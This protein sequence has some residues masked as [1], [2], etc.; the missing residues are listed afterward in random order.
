MALNPFTYDDPVSPQE[1]IDRSEVLV[2]LL[3]LAEGGHN[4]RLQA[5][6]RYG[7]TS[8]LLKLCQEAETAGFRTIYVDFMLATTPAE[9]ARRI[10]EA[11]LRALKGPLGQMFGR[12]RRTWKG[13]LKAA[14]GGVG[15]ELEYG[16]DSDATQRLADLLD[17]P[18]RVLETTGE[19]TI[20][21][22]DEFQDFLRA[23]GKLDGLLRS[24]IQHHGDAASYIFSGSEQALLE[25]YFNSRK[26]PLFDQ[27]RPI[28]LDPL[29][30]VDL[31][32]YI[33]SRFSATGKDSGEI[34]DLLLGIARGHPQ[35]AML[36]AHHLWEATDDGGVATED[37]MDRSLEQIDR[38]TK[39]RFEGTWQAIAGTANKRRTLKALAL[40][41]ETL[42][43]QR[44]LRRFKL[45]K[46]Q[47]QSGER[48]L[49]SSG[50][51]VRVDGRATIVDPL[52]ERWI[53]VQDSS[54]AAKPAPE[55][56]DDARRAT[57]GGALR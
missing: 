48:G 5:P 31:G 12:M 54:P 32:D 24:K 22:F 37:T 53:Q 4:T 13:R 35:R 23:E 8:V 6:R 36:L 3:E 50:E 43:N 15:A 21:V 44:T 17:L 30:S 25:E 56:P 27:A 52:L 57:H 28:Y 26:R 10:E 29:D 19:R 7:K 46:G 51:V 45:S 14:P 1:L 34:L 11:Y 38:E 9:I 41:D 40:S 16:A 33:A 18:L 55:D 2:K 49:I 20:V 47:A 42:Y 39:E